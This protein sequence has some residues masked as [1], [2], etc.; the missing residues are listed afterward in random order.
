MAIRKY[1]VVD[2]DGTIAD[3]THRLHHLTKPKKDWDK[4]FE[5]CANDEPIQEIVDL[6]KTMNERNYRVIYLTGRVGTDETRKATEEWLVKQGLWDYEAL[7]MR[8][9]GDFRVDRIVKPELLTE[10]I[11]K[12]FE[13]DEYGVCHNDVISLILEDRTSVV[14]VFRKLG[15]KVLQV[16]EG[17]F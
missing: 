15:Y 12:H 7:L 9:G 10:Y 17:N 14:E 2:I 6:V 5:E 4:F 16:A 11:T 13:H 8:E 3:C 1:V